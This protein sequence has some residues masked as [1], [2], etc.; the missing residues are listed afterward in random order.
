MHKKKQL[1][2]NKKEYPELSAPIDIDKNTEL[3]YFSELGSEE[4]VKSMLTKRRFN[5]DMG[6]HHQS[7]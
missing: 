4:N 1:K 5:F 7:N 2:L 3:A 6:R